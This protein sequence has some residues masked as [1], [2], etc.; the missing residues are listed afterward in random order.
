VWQARSIYW[1]VG[2]PLSQTRLSE[3]NAYTGSSSPHPAT[4]EAGFR[5]PSPISRRPIRRCGFLLSVWPPTAGRDPRILILA[6]RKLRKA[7]EPQRKGGQDDRR[8]ESKTVRQRAGQAP[9]PRQTGG[10]HQTHLLFPSDLCKC[11]TTWIR[12]QD[13][14]LT[15]LMILLGS[16]L[17]HRFC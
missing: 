4:P 3:G 6:Q 2:P 5:P 10:M 7:E 9:Q 15:G 8:G 14:D 13:V 16:L 17:I 1:Q 12:A 11:K